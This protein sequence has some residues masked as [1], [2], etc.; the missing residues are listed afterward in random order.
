MFGKSWTSSRK[1]VPPVR[2]VNTTGSAAAAA[3]NAPPVLSRRGVIRRLCTCAA[4]GS[5]R[6]VRDRPLSPGVGRSLALLVAARRVTGRPATGFAATIRAPSAYGRR[7]AP[8]WRLCRCR[9]R[10]RH[11]RRAAAA[12]TDRRSR[13]HYRAQLAVGLD[14]KMSKFRYCTRVCV[15]VCILVYIRVCVRARVMVPVD[16]GSHSPMT[17]CAPL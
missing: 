10:R 5:I 8:S 12:V 16:G 15:C 1:R 13:R 17:F 2:S 9:R 4:D 11:R 14:A 7:R 3:D 6:R